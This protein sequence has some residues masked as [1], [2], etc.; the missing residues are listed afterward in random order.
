MKQMKL[1]FLPDGQ[2]VLPDTLTP[3]VFLP[4]T[5]GCLRRWRWGHSR[6]LALGPRLQDATERLPH[7][8]PT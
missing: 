5:P 8:A 1:P 7:P 4:H 3:S 6:G 2:A